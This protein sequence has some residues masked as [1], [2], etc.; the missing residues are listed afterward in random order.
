MPKSGGLP[1]VVQP[2]ATDLSDYTLAGA[3]QENRT[4]LTSVTE[5]SKQ[6]I[7]RAHV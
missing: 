2:F 3:V 7:G 6:E 5:L 4:L 1:S